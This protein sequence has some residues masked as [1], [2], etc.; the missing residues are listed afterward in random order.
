MTLI[1]SGSVPDRLITALLG[2]CAATA[3]M[4]PIAA[5]AQ[6]AY[7]SRT[8]TLVVPFPAGS[9]SDMSARLLAKDMS[10]TM[11]QTVVVDNR[12]LANGALGS[13]AVARARPDGYTL[14][15]GVAATHAAN[16]AFYPG[17]LGYQPS[18][19][20]MVGGLGMV[21]VSLFVTANAPWK[22]LAEL[23]ADAKK[24]PGKVACG[25]GTTVAQVA[26]EV[27]K[28]R[29]GIDLLN[30]P[31]KGSPPA[32]TDLASGQVQ[33]V[34]A[35]GTSAAPLLENK[36]L[37]VLATAAGKRVP[38]WP[39]VPTFVE[40]GMAD[41]EISAWSAL[42]APAG[43]PAAVLQRL[44]AATRRSAELPEAVAARQ[45]SGSL[46]LVMTLDEGRRFVAAEVERWARLVKDSGVK[47][48]Q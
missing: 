24:H 18:S 44:N 22:T 8:I 9:G 36:R 38:F 6:D 23:I 33:V 39:E 7:P 13:Q 43:T 28:L 14:L 4:L 46:P 26:C 15:V 41:L 34:F 16:Y 2:L 5:K 47:L 3:A 35:D 30:V 12:P 10:E 45:R 31:Y 20:E 27:F 17:K 11:G 37:R 40:L 25:S 19:F 42:F 21:P 48:E 1:T 32:L 29:A